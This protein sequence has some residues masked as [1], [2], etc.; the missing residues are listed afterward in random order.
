MPTTKKDDPA[1]FL[2]LAIIGLDAPDRG[3]AGDTRKTGGDDD[4]QPAGR[5]AKAAG[6]GS[7]VSSQ[8]RLGQKS[9]P[10]Q[11][12]A[13]PGRGRRK[14]KNKSRSQTQRK[15][16]QRP[17]RRKPNRL[18][19]RRRNLRGKRENLSRPRLKEVICILET[20]STL[21]FLLSP[22]LLPGCSNSLFS[23]RTPG[24]HGSFNQSCFDDARGTF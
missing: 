9:A 4:G 21:L 3:V 12:H 23:T 20:A 13:G 16:K 17:S 5:T 11:K 7:N 18:L 1:E 2:R 6:Q 8:R 24:R 22:L 19:P 10:P 14:R 15:R